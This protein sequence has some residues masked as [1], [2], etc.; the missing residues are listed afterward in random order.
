MFQKFY[1]RVFSNT[2]INAI[3]GLIN[4]DEQEQPF[5]TK[6]NEQA[7]KYITTQLSFSGHK[8]NR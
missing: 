8:S 4:A 1:Y 3:N 2:L 6:S 5:N 7:N